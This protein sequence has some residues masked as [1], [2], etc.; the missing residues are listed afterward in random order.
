MGRVIPTYG[1][2]HYTTRSASQPETNSQTPHPPLVSITQN[3]FGFS[4]SL[5]QLVPLP[6]YLF[7]PLPPT[8]PVDFCAGNVRNPRSNA[9][10]W[11]YPFPLFPCVFLWFLALSRAVIGISIPPVR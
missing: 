4:F 8:K 9:E 3:S 1:I 5:R 7:D 11:D 2:L 6:P 10:E